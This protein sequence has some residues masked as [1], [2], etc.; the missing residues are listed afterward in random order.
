LQELS[1]DRDGLTIFEN[2]DHE[3]AYREIRYNAA[4]ALA[5]RGSTRTPWHLVLETLDEDRL[6]DRYYR[7]DKNAAV[8]F[9]LKALR[10]LREL[11]RHHPEVFARQ[12][13][14]AEAVAKLAHSPTI[15]IQ[16][17]AQ[18]LLGSTPA[19]EGSPT[20]F[21]REVLLIVSLGVGVF[22]FLALAVIARWRRRP[23]KEIRD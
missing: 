12:T 3:R 8:A 9:V 7:N 16:V 6:D 20:R 10:D 19:E 21:S 4:L 18:K 5:R 2:D 11:K 23:V 17:E 15:A 1:A 22:L 14:V 13:D